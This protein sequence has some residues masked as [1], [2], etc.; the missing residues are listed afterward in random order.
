MLK[1]FVDAY[2]HHTS[3]SLL[4]ASCVISSKFIGK[5]YLFR[6]LLLLSRKYFKKVEK[7]NLRY[8]AWASTGYHHYT[9]T[10]T[11]THLHALRRTHTHSQSQLLCTMKKDV[12]KTRRKKNLNKK[13]I[14]VGNGAFCAVYFFSSPSQASTMCQIKVESLCLS[15]CL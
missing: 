3:I 5:Y 11:Y 6:C 4:V 14:L 13:E 7:K 10:H 8:R 15:C 9:H 2:P 1:A 12:F